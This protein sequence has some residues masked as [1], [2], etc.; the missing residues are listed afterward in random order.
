M[1]SSSYK[2]QDYP[3]RDRDTMLQT[4]KGF[5]FVETIKAAIVKRKDNKNI[6]KPA[7]FNSRTQIVINPN[8]FRP[9]L[10]A[11]QQQLMN[12]I[13]VWLSEG[14]WW[15]ISSIDE[16]Y[17]NIVVYD[18]LKGSSR[19]QLPQELQTPN[20]GLINL[21]NEDND[22]FRW[23]HIR[24]LNP[25]ENNPQRIKKSDK[26][27]VEQLNYQHTEFPV[28]VKHYNKIEKQNN[29]NINVFGYENKQF[30]PI[31]VS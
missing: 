15:A 6:Y 18:P 30:Y 24:Y 22:C 23:C 9:D 17:I 27:M 7:Y 31:Y 20:K 5:K 28:A 12:S 1:P 11:S 19:I 14:S 16:H 29:I 25:K 10:Q 26:R 21:E 8:D 13:G 2:I 3:L 4:T